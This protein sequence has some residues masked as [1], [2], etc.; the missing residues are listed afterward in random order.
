M[1]DAILAGLNETNGGHTNFLSS[2][3]YTLNGRVLYQ[4][5]NKNRPL[6]LTGRSTLG[7]SAISIVA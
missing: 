1:S 2:I 5:N 6:S 3:D 4:R 7:N